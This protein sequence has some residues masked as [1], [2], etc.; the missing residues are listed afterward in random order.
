MCKASDGFQLSIK[1][2]T[3]QYITNYAL[4]DSLGVWSGEQIV[5]VDTSGLDSSIKTG[6]NDTILPISSQPDFLVRP[7]FPDLFKG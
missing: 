1:H 3:K 7:F 2:L 4:E 6:Q 5:L